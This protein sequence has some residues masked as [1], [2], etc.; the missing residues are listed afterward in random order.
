MSIKCPRCGET[1]NTYVPHE[2]KKTEKGQF[3]I[4][5]TSL[6]FECVTCKKVHELSQ[7]HT[8]PQ[9]AEYGEC[10]RD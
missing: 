1:D 7:V 3:N 9:H 8:E 5:E 2:K 6:T 10:P 4:V